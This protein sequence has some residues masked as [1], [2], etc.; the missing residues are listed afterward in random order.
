MLTKQRVKKRGGGRGRSSNPGV[1][2]AQSRAA[3]QSE[4]E[5]EEEGGREGERAGGGGGEVLSDSIFLCMTDR[6]AEVPALHCLHTSTS[7]SEMSC[8]KEKWRYREEEEE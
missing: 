2:E 5:K 3:H 1:S 4:E 7:E 8:K 6:Q